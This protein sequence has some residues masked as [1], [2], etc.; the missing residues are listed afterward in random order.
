MAYGQARSQRL[1]DRGAI[2]CDNTADLVLRSRRAINRSR[3][4]LGDSR[5]I[6]DRNF[7]TVRAACSLTSI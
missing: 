6:V 4:L 2:L 3:M 5:R 7:E 1:R